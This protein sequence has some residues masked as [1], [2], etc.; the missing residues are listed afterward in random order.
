MLDQLLE[1]RNAALITAEEAGEAM[2]F[3]MLDTVRDYSG[4]RLAE[5]GE[6]VRLRHLD[7][8]LGL[9]EHADRVLEGYG[10]PTGAAW[11]ECLDTE[12]DNLR[13]AL[14]WCLA[15]GGGAERGLR[16]AAA[17]VPFWEARGYLSEG[18]SYL[19]KALAREAD[20]AN[21]TGPSA[22]RHAMPTPERANA[23]N[24]AAVL[25][26]MQGD[27]A[28]AR[29]LLEESLAA[30]PELGRGLEIAWSIQH[31]AHLAS[32]QGDYEMA[33]GLYK[34]SLAMFRELEHPS[35]IASSLA[36]QGNVALKQ[37]DFEAARSFYE[38]SL[39]I[40]RELG[41]PVNIAIALNNLGKIAREQG[42]LRS[43]RAL[44]VE[45]LEIRRALGDKGGFPWSL[46]AFARLAALVD[47]ERAAKLWGA[48][49][50]LRNSLGLP[51]PPNERPEYDRSVAGVREALGQEAFM[52]AWAAGQE[53]PM[54]E[55]IR[56]ALEPEVQVFQSLPKL[57]EDFAPILCCFGAPSLQ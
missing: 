28:A 7:W 21:A 22:P 20:G 27:S 32:T 42:D 56:Y 6:A 24:V 26:W 13:A 36:E 54:E 43:A 8:Y 12:H 45:S 49:E 53:M 47:L 34:E 3:R 55:A 52:K 9:A 18:R 39:A 38:G 2:R 40:S 37:G 14:D 5:W 11:W 57:C 48:A 30:S 41:H 19:A 51:L 4:E 10:R 31:L 16:L 46:E 35:G 23:L 1:L 33:Q 50:V 15:E 29:M 17:L 25:A 44:H